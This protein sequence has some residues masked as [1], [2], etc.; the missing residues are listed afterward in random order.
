MYDGADFNWVYDDEHEDVPEI[1]TK[2]IMIIGGIILGLAMIIGFIF[3]KR[4]AS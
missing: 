3:K 1:P 4:K 2:N